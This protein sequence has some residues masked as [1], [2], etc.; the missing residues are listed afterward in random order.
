MNCCRCDDV[1]DM[2]LYCMNSLDQAARM[3]NVRYSFQFALIRA[4]SSAARRTDCDADLSVAANTLAFR[5]LRTRSMV[6]QP[7]AGAFAETQIVAG[8][9][10]RLTRRGT[11]RL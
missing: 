4:G 2:H 6:S 5:T 9:M 3:V 11:G 10:A 1:L 7:S 8:D